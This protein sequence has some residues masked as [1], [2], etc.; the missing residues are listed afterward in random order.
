M[1]YTRNK[2]TCM[3]HGAIIL[4]VDDENRD[5]VTTT[6]TA[7]AGSTDHKEMDKVH[8]HTHTHTHTHMRYC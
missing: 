8:T 5:P 4:Q 3:R 2:T 1:N 7:S 6:A